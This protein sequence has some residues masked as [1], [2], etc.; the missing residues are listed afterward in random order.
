MRK[1]NIYLETSAWNFLF[2][3]D[4]PE[5]RDKTLELFKEIEDGKYG[6]YISELV[7]TEIED[8]KDNNKRQQLL[9]A[10]KKYSPKEL[11]GKKDEV[12]E[13]TAKYLGID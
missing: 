1:L 5:K 7:I 6:I 13:L 11:T 3:E 12:S 10:V 4:A 9:Q 8:T 2:V